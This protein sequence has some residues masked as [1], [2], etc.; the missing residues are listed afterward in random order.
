M[1]MHFREFVTHT[2]IP[3]AGDGYQYSDM[4]VAN[5]Y[6]GNYPGAKVKEIAM[7]TGRSV[8]ELYRIL[9]KHGSPNRLKQNYHSVLT[10]ADSGMDVNRIAELT[11]YTPRNVRYILKNHILK[12]G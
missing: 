8:G 2:E 1:E 11:G 9:H 3:H 4:E 5:L 7:I 12:E 6:Y 10:F